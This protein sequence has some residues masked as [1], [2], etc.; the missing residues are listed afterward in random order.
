[1]ADIYVS[2][3]FVKKEDEKEATKEAVIENKKRYTP[4]KLRKSLP[5]SPLSPF[6]FLPKNVDFETRDGEEKV[7][8]L[9][10]RHPITNLRWI[11]VAILM[12]FAPLVLGYFPIIDFLPPNFRFVSLVGWYMIVFAYVF[13]SFLS[14][15]FAVN[16][17]TDE[18]IVDIDFYNLI[19]KEVSDTSLDKIQDVT[20]KVG[21][22]LGTLLNY[23]DVLIQTA[24]EVP[25]FEFSLVP[26]PEKV[27]E[28]LQQLREEEEQEKIEGRVK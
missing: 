9:L 5:F 7:V 14:W 24:G 15:F 16:I 25:R 22:V 18:R 10:R 8:L 23:G 3:P 27:A 2:K 1:M 6:G 26:K 11:A 21:G 13:E 20:Y 17:V 28:I 4:F 12:S 19:Y